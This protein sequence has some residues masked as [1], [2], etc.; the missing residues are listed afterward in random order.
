MYLRM[1]SSLLARIR[2]L[3]WGWAKLESTKWARRVPQEREYVTLRQHAPHTCALYFCCIRN[4]V[5]YQKPMYGWDER[6]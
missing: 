1:S 2:F 3:N 5:F 6:S 4:A